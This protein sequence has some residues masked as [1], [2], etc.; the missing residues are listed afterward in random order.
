M[1]EKYFFLVNASAGNGKKIALWSDVILPELNRRGIHYRMYRLEHRGHATCLT[2]K[3]IA[4]NE[5]EI[6]IIVV[7]G[8]G[9][10]NEMLNGITDFERVT[11]GV[12]PAGSGNDLCYGLGIPSDPLQALSVA[13]RNDHIVKMDIGR[14]IFHKDDMVKYFA[15][16]CGIGLDA[17]VCARTEKSKCKA[18]LNRLHIGNLSYFINTL[19]A[20]FGVKHADATLTTSQKDGKPQSRKVKRMIFLAAMNQRY[21]GGH[22]PMSPNA[23]C[24]D[25]ALSCVM[26]YDM[27]KPVALGCLGLLIRGKHILAKKIDVIPIKSIRITLDE[28]REVHTDGEVHGLYDD[29]TIE[30][31]HRKLKIC[32]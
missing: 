13:L 29:I 2:Q 12:I 31:H 22:L 26:A 27:A 9:T 15:I 8:D 4:E 24:F 23:D 19:G 16:S 10:F 11:V 6:R 28:P 7:G 20:L 1:S 32:K 14:T 18:I 17:E 25:G 21:E 3:I 5:G 30:C